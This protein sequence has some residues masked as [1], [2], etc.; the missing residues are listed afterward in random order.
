MAHLLV[1]LVRSL[2]MFLMRRPDSSYNSCCGHR[3]C[4]AWSYKNEDTTSLYQHPVLCMIPF[5]FVM[6]TLD[7]K[8]V[9]ESI[10]TCPWL[11]CTAR[12]TT[13][14]HTSNALHPTF[15]F[16]YRRKSKSN[17]PLLLMGVQV[18]WILTFVHRIAVET[19][20]IP[21]LNIISNIGLGDTETNLTVPGK[22]I[23]RRPGLQSCWLHH[24]NTCI[25]QLLLEYTSA[26]IVVAA[27]D[28]RYIAKLPG[29]YRWYHFQSAIKILPA[30]QLAS[31]VF[32]PE[33]D[34]QERS[35][36]HDVGSCLARL[37]KVY[38]HNQIRAACFLP[39]IVNVSQC[40]E[41]N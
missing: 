33:V 11:W 37:M 36:A 24:D 6:Y 38:Q 7:F 13:D 3:V 31:I 12:I 21:L 10:G 30:P 22:S 41:H 1:N 34:L 40:G 29:V 14:I 4:L 35:V 19:H 26:I 15:G 32:D 8:T 27:L 17:A 18:T 5:Y 2:T 20:L 39:H 23:T 28:T 9:L 25:R 16:S